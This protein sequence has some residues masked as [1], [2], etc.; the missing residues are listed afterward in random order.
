MSMEETSAQI[1]EVP[2]I[3]PVP[4]DAVTKLTVTKAFSTA[5]ILAT[6]S[7]VVILPIMVIVGVLMLNLMGVIILDIGDVKL[8]ALGVVFYIICLTACIFIEMVLPAFALSRIA[9]SF[10]YGLDERQSS[11]KFLSRITMTV[12]IIQWVSY[13]LLIFV[14]LQRCY[15]KLTSWNPNGLKIGLIVVALLIGFIHTAALQMIATGVRHFYKGT[16]NKQNSLWCAVGL[17]VTGAFEIGNM[18]FILW[19][20]IP[21][22]DFEYIFSPEVLAAP[23]FAMSA[24][25]AHGVCLVI[26]GIL[27]ITKSRKKDWFELS[28]S[29]AE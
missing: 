27:L 9:N 21:S 16:A 19:N 18:V 3:I 14:C 25:I 2:E 12:S 11:V 29:T 13:I 23:F 15:E 6:V 1:S 28:I 22:G 20:L 8:Y 10:K 17:I 7:A 5:K 4:D 26:L 24:F